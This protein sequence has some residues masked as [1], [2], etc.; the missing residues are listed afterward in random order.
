MIVHKGFGRLLVA[1]LLYL[2]ISP[3]IHPTSIAALGVHAWLSLVLFF[4]ARAVHKNHKRFSITQALLG[5]ALLLY[6]LG[7]F[8]IVPFSNQAALGLFVIFYALLI[9][10][11]VRQLFNST[12]V[13][14]ELIAAT[15][16]LYLIIGLFWGSVYNLTY[17]LNS[18]AFAGNLIEQAS[19]TKLHVFNYFSMVTLTTLGYGDITPQTPGAAGLCQMEAIIGQFFTAVLV[20]WLVGMYRRPTDK[21]LQD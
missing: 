16:C 17:S 12:E 3:F 14:G 2:I 20:A 18:E 8:K 11:F 19:E 7:I 6:W 21:Q 4:A 1:L 15:L 5:P 10:A 13:S 9:Y